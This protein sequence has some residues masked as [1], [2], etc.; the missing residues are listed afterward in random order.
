[1]VASNA[2]VATPAVGVHYAAR[3]YAIQ[4]ERLQTLG[5][6]IRDLAHANPSDSS[7]ILSSAH[8]D[9]LVETPVETLDQN[10]SGFPHQSQ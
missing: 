4:K 8:Q 5:R 10:K 1:M 3:L 2:A 6:G 7:S 9:G